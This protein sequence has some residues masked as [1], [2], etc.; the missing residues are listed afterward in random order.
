MRALFLCSFPGLRFCPQ[1]NRARRQKIRPK[2]RS[3]QAWGA[4]RPFSMHLSTGR[5]YQVLWTAGGYLGRVPQSKYPVLMQN[6]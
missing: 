5:Q 1:D 3:Y 6:S 2:E 4:F